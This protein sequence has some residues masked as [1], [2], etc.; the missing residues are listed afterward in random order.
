MRMK[1]NERWAALGAAFGLLCKDQRAAQLF[2]FLFFGPFC[3]TSGII[4]SSLPM[5]VRISFIVTGVIVMGWNG[6][7][8]YQTDKNQ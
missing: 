4:Y 2:D 3:I 1:C 6:W 8:I 7:Q 5:N